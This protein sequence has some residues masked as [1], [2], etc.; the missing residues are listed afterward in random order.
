M[1]SWD[2]NPPR[3]LCTR[4]QPSRFFFSQYSSTRR[5]IRQRPPRESQHEENPDSPPPPPHESRS[6]GRVEIGEMQTAFPMILTKIMY[7]V[8]CI[9]FHQFLLYEVMTLHEISRSAPKEMITGNTKNFH[10]SLPY[11]DHFH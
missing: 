10:M 6:L 11:T 5:E 3:I 8:L 7:F 1:D 2:S 4:K 9:I